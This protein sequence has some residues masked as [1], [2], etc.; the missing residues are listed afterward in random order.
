M[1]AASDPTGAPLPEVAE[2]RTQQRSADTQAQTDL[3]LVDDAGVVRAIVEVK[4]EAGLHGDQLTS[5]LEVFGDG[6]GRLVLL[7]PSA[8][9]DLAGAAALRRLRDRPIV[10]GP[11]CN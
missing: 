9:Q 1:L 2:V 6:G 11:V 4:L 8:R 5:Y 3:E 7:V 10:R